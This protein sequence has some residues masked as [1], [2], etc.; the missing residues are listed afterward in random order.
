MKLGVWFH[1]HKFSKMFYMYSDSRH[2][3]YDK[4]LHQVMNMVDV[5][6]AGKVQTAKIYHVGDQTSGPQILAWK[7]GGWYTPTNK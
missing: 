3:D 2:K 6:W 1:N 7:E 4:E 5:K